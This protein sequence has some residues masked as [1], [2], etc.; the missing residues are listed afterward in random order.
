MPGDVRC[1]APVCKHVHRRRR[2]SFNTLD[3]PINQQRNYH[4]RTSVKSPDT[5][6]KRAFGTR[7]AQG[8]NH[9]TQDLFRSSNLLSGFLNCLT[10]YRDVGPKSQ[11]PLGHTASIQSDGLEVIDRRSMFPFLFPVQLPKLKRLT[12]NY[13]TARMSSPLAREDS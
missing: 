7:V 6:G 11:R 9:G 3:S 1:R 5:V 2:D 10:V 12:L 4:V 8:T 13:F